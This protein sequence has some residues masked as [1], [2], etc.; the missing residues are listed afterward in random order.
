MHAF[1]VNVHISKVLKL[2][3]Q[4]MHASI[5]ISGRM[6]RML[7][8]Q[9]TGNHALQHSMTLASIVDIV[10]VCQIQSMLHL[11][12]PALFTQ[13]ICGG[14]PSCRMASTAGSVFPPRCDPSRLPEGA[15]E[16]AGPDS[17]L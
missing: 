13:V 5:C 2:C 15:R 9:Q 17:R 6:L 1:T 8:K 16:A 3:L 10:N 11:T 14:V 4:V 7:Y 12:M